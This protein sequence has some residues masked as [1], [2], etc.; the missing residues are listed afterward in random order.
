MSRLLEIWRN[1][2]AVGKCLSQACLGLRIALLGFDL[3]R[4]HID[5]WRRRFGDNR[6]CSSW[7]KIQET[8]GDQNANC[9]HAQDKDASFH[10]A[11][12]LIVPALRTYDCTIKHFAQYIMCERLAAQDDF[13]NC[14]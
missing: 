14:P 10:I 11:F 12:D 3:Q 7:S 13:M 6:A 2:H 8:C 4:G 9:R 1:P 5:N